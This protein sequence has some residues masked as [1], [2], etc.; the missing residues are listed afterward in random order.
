M[1]KIIN[2]S[3]DSN[4]ESEKN[5]AGNFAEKLKQK[6]VYSGLTEDQKINI[7]DGKYGPEIKEE[8]QKY[9]D[10]DFIDALTNLSHQKKHNLSKFT[11]DIELYI[12]LL[13]KKHANNDISNCRTEI[14]GYAEK[15]L[16]EDLGY[17][18]LK[19]QEILSYS[20]PE[21]T[22][23]IQFLLQKNAKQDRRFHFFLKM[24]EHVIQDKIYID[25]NLGSNHD[26]R[27]HIRKLL[28][29]N[30]NQIKFLDSHEEI[31]GLNTHLSHISRLKRNS[32]ALF[33]YL[34]TSFSSNPSKTENNIIEV[35]KAVDEL[36]KLYDLKFDVDQI[37]INHKEYLLCKRE[38]EI[39]N[40]G[41]S[42]QKINDLFNKRKKLFDYIQYDL[43]QYNIIDKKINTTIG[44]INKIDQDSIDPIKKHEKLENTLKKNPEI[45][46]IKKTIE[47][48]IINITN[49]DFLDSRLNNYYQEIIAKIG[50]E[51]SSEETRNKIVWNLLLDQ[52]AIDYVA[53]L[54]KKEQG[55]LFNSRTT[56]DYPQQ[57]VA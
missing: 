26:L 22:K 1:K 10:L 11:Q 47:A 33:V 12:D 27:R 56:K 31:V 51:I 32:W 57:E 52:T 4:N 23:Q 24:I 39:T 54:Y 38:Y 29:Q 18:I 28:D 13:K 49:P 37:E 6:E 20:S 2:E 34:K 9:T 44:E 53:E 17:K 21:F 41:H 7:I 45:N 16:K 5:N 14:V 25:D 46:D 30:L 40:S 8:Y 35:T 48:K 43:D 36:Y 15:L 55:N 42:L 19:N 3:I 50:P